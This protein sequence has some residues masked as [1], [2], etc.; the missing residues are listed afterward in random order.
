MAFIFVEAKKPSSEAIPVACK[1]TRFTTDHSSPRDHVAG[2][3]SSS[4]FRDAAG[5]V[6]FRPAALVAV[7]L[8][9]NFS[10]KL[11]GDGKNF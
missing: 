3:A 10:A 1:K 4:Q 8:E 5:A 2:L 7:V 6:D 9:N 11:G